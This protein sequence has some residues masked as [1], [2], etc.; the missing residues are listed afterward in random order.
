MLALTIGEPCL[1]ISMKKESIVTKKVTG[2]PSKIMGPVD[3]LV[4][5]FPG[6]RFSGL[7]APELKKL[8]KKGLIRVIDLVFVLKDMKGKISITETK[9]LGG[10]EGDAFSEFSQKVNEWLSEADIEVF[11]ESLPNNC[12]AAILL[13]ENTWAIPFKNALLKTGAELVDQGRIPNEVI[14]KVEQ[15]LIPP[16]GE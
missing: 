3:F 9:N 1:R 12:S 8:E 5:R 4:V 11:S 10:V 16:D 14:R 6:N 7:I 13:F 2:K 15:D